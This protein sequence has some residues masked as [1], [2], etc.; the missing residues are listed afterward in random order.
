M[1]D[2][3]YVI[4]QNNLLTAQAKQDL[5]RFYSNVKE[6]PEDYVHNKYIVINGELVLNPDFEQE[7]IRKERQRVDNLKCTKRVFVLMLEELGLN[8]FE[9]IQ[10]AI[11]SNRQAKLEWE[12]C[13]E[14]LRANPL[15][16]TLAQQ[17]GI[18]SLQLDLIFK[19]ANG[20]NTIEELRASR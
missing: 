6:L 19:T 8:Y 2:K 18:T 11:N 5:E 13:V 1:S 3:F 15:I 14:L 16:D 7:E 4:E 12:L 17:F 9:Q 10:P 20:E